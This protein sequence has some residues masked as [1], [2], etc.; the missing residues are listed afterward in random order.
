MTILLLLIT[1]VMC[2]DVTFHYYH[3]YHY[4]ML[5]TSIA[6]VVMESLLY[7]YVLGV[8][9]TSNYYSSNDSLTT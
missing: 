9:N 7:R 8:S 6:T 2:L 5:I 1:A 4:A 3:Y